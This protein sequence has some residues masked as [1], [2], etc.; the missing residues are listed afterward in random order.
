MQEQYIK[1][2][3]IEKEFQLVLYIDKVSNHKTERCELLNAIKATIKGDL[4]VGYKL[5]RHQLILFRYMTPLTLQ[6]QK[7][8][9][10]C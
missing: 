2:C 6:H 9:L 1:K 10:A 8:C 5:D 7:L 4:F 3:A